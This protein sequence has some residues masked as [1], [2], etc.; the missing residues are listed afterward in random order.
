MKRIFLFFLL[1]ANTVLCLAQEENKHGLQTCD[2]IALNR[3]HHVLSY[4]CL[5]NS[6]HDVI[7]KVFKGGKLFQQFNVGYVYLGDGETGNDHVRLADINFDGYADYLI[8]MDFPRYGMAV[9]LY[10]RKTHEFEYDENWLLQSP[11]FDKKNQIIYTLSNNGPA[12]FIIRTMMPYK[13]EIITGTTLRI[14]A[15]VET[16]NQNSSPEFRVENKYEFLGDDEKCYEGYNKSS[17]LP[18]EWQNVLDAYGLSD[19]YFEN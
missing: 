4:D 8:G 16:F 1:L 13:G 11:L 9:V 7:F 6:D 12:Q 19:Q 17:S 14:T 10:N 3:M 18:L 5:M 2:D 15:D